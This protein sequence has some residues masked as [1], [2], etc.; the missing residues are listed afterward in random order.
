MKLRL[1]LTLATLFA[2]AAQASAVFLDFLPYAP[3]APTS[4]TDA[5]TGINITQLSGVVGTGLVA[6][7]GDY[8]TTSA[9]TPAGS[10]FG[11]YVDP[12]GLYMLGSNAC[13][14]YTSPSPRDAT[15]SRMPSSA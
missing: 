11:G 14:L 4:Y 3:T 13:L 6:P 7:F 12:A 9:G 2:F 5:G 8:V 15:L 10:Q 1:L